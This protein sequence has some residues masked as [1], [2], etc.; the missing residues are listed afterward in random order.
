[1]LF[2]ITQHGTLKLR[3]FTAAAILIRV[4]IRYKIKD[5]VRF[6]EILTRNSSQWEPWLQLLY[7]QCASSDT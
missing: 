5:Q 7:L 3:V 6:V 1:M 2:K 4:C